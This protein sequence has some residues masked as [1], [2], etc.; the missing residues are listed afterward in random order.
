MLLPAIIA[1]SERLTIFLIVVVCLLPFV[2]AIFAKSLGGY[3]TS[4]NQ[5]PRVFLA[6]LTGA[7][8]RLNAAQSNSFEGLP[9]F[10]VSVLVAMHYFVPTVVINQMLM[11]YV[12]SRILYI[13]AYAKNWALFRS[14]VWGV[15]TVSCLVLLYFAWFII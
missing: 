1:D 9:L 11:V 13:I 8:S 3:R 2:C 10:V 12:L 4:D 6:N 7:A 15:G 5:Q 14:V